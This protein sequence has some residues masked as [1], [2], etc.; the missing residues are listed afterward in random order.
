MS[1]KTATHTPS[2][3]LHGYEV[4]LFPAD[5][6]ENALRFAIGGIMDLV[7]QCNG[8][9]SRSCGGR[10][11]DGSCGSIVCNSIG[12]PPQSGRVT[13]NKFDKYGVWQGSDRIGSDQ[14][15]SNQIKSDQIK[16]D[17][18]KSNQIRSDQTK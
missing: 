18:I 5:F 8:G 4:G 7:T 15:K 12:T 2:G 1:F 17:Q 13:S 3:A 16:S 9:G 11:Y 14:I 10:R 6:L